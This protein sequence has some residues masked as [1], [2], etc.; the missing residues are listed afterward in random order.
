MIGAEKNISQHFKTMIERLSTLKDADSKGKWNGDSPVPSPKGSY[1]GDVESNETDSADDNDST[2]EDEISKMDSEWSSG[3]DYEEQSPQPSLPLHRAL[4]EPF[5]WHTAVDLLS[6]SPFKHRH[7]NDA[8]SQRETQDTSLIPD[9]TDDIDDNAFADELIDEE[10]LDVLDV[11]ASKK[12]EDKLWVNFEHATSTMHRSEEEQMLILSSENES[13]ASQV[14][15]KTKNK[16]R[17]LRYAE[18]DSSSRVKSQVYVI[19][20]D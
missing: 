4:N 17:S 15:R 20:S 3:D 7:G 11:V 14:E 6:P 18:A 13:V 1:A 16:G 2:A 12:A 10:E 5:V 9:D 19:D 8:K